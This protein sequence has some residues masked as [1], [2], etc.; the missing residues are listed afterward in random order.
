MYGPRGLGH[1]GGRPAEQTTY[2]PLRSL[3]DAARI[4]QV[5]EELTGVQF[6]TT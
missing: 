1:L 6:P 3:D 2:R 5:S 4:W